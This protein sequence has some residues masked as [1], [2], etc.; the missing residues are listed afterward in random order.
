MYET[1]LTGLENMLRQMPIMAEMQRLSLVFLPDDVRKF[2]RA[3]DVAV[4]LDTPKPLL[5]EPMIALEI[6]PAL[7]HRLPVVRC[8]HDPL[9]TELNRV[10]L[11]RYELIATSMLRQSQV[12][13][14]IA[15]CADAESVVLMLVDGLSYADL[16]RYANQWLSHT[17]PVLVDGVSNTEQGMLRNIGRPA[18]AQRLFDIGFRNCIGFTY[19]ERAEEPITDRLFTGFGDRVHKVKSF[20]EALTRLEQKCDNELRGIFIQIVR[21][22]LDNVAHRQREIPNIAACVTEIMTDFERLASFFERRK[23]ATQLYLLADHGIL[24]AQEHNLQ[25]YE[26]S[27]AEHPRYYEHARHS[28]YVLTVEFEGKEFALLD[29][30]Y[31]RRELRA[32]EWG[33]HGGLSFEESI[34]PFVSLRVA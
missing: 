23:V 19:W 8:T 3:W 30:P 16:K 14:K 26:F 6:E 11:K 1:D 27:T 7:R 31:L 24:W 17:T 32:N 2:A 10:L 12:T 15:P 13:D 25:V 29:Y 20:D 22:G 21:A 28:E 33:V 5:P 4:E 9:T 18:L 34:V